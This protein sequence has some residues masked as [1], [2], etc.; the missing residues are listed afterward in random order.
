MPSLHRSSPL[1][2]VACLV[3]A[4]SAQA[5]VDRSFGYLRT[6][7]G[8][9]SL[10]TATGERTDAE[11]NLPI[12]VGDRLTLSREARADLV[13]PD[14]IV[15]RLDG[16]S[17]LAFVDLAA[18]PESR[19]EQTLL[20]M[21]EGNLV[22][23]VPERALSGNAV[24]RIDTPN[25]TI[26]LQREGNYR[27]T[28]LDG[29]WT[30]VTVRS[31][32]AEVVSRRGSAVLRADEELVVEGTDWPRHDARV[33]D[34]EDSL[35]RWA[36]ALD[37]D[38]AGV[39]DRYVDPDLAHATAP[40]RRHGAWVDA[41]GR[42]A[43]RP[44]V[45]A[46]WS[47][48]RR[49]RWIYTTSGICWVSYEPWGWLTYHYGTWD[50]LPG[51]G[52]VW[53]P[54]RHF[55]PAWVYWYWGSDWVGWAPIGVYTRYYGRTYG[56]DIGFRWGYH[57]WVRGWGGFDDWW[58]FS[59][60]RD[61][62]RRD[63]RDRVVV[64]L[65]LRN[66][67]ADG[68]L[69]TDTRGFTSEVWGNPGSRLSRLRDTPEV[70]RLP[71][72]DDFVARKPLPREVEGVVLRRDRDPRRE[73][74]PGRVGLPEIPKPLPEPEDRRNTPRDGRVG[75]DLRERVN[76]PR[77]GEEWRGAPK[78]LPRGEERPPAEGGSGRVTLPAPR[79]GETPRGEVPR[80]TETPRGE[81]PRD[82]EPPRG[83]DERW[84]DG[85]EPAR[86]PRVEANPTPPPP[87]D[88]G[89][90]GSRRERITEPAPSSPPPAQRVIG[91]GDEDWRSS[92]GVRVLPRGGDPGGRSTQPTE[93]PPGDDSW[94]RAG[95][96]W[97]TIY[98]GPTPDG[99]ATGRERQGDDPVVRRVIEGVRGGGRRDE[100]SAQAPSGTPYPGATRRVEPAPSD[101]RR[102]YPTVGTPGSAP[103]YRQPTPPSTGSRQPS[104]P[105]R[106]ETT[107]PSP[108]PSSS[109][110]V[111]GVSG[112]GSSSSGSR[113]S[114]SS[115]NRPP[116]S[117]GGSRESVRSHGTDGN[118]RPRG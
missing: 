7:E 77:S 19:D 116:G 30:Q 57:G 29:D 97:P 41:D 86:P 15:L 73:T 35:E 55:A 37:R 3:W 87:R 66:E 60:P 80:R 10:I 104:T 20:E 33:A 112:A 100:G 25:A 18:A 34:R 12:A 71:A 24:P 117:S 23:G 11:M 118:G 49:G 74:Q 42:R 70:A 56:W 85:R 88:T 84:R 65:S 21:P 8:G 91:G 69:L 96:R 47:P 113:E 62:G 108:P 22:L 92:R 16:G 13:L 90:E 79:G 14:H 31:G 109:R 63:L 114:T 52:W 107:R 45:G 54:D 81:T 40:L 48:Y 102:S 58:C 94:R 32:V 26:Y 68:L 51:W 2:A 111:G 106:T 95:S 61:L 27:I 17:E 93:A 36:R 83:S 39:D 4:V 1:A 43:W 28:T 103:G 38:Y 98:L 6:L 75:I 46:D 50:Y 64:G 82:S 78:P 9:G 5:Q 89:G 101:S 110:A 72:V 99:N 53:Y 44:S 115:G 76:P 59:R 105:P 67:R